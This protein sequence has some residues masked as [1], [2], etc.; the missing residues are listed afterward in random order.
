ML[1]IHGGAGIH[2][3]S[4]DKAC[5]SAIKIS[6][7]NLINAIMVKILCKNKKKYPGVGK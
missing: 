3:S 4:V 1:V 7:Q 5:S 2:N 6:N